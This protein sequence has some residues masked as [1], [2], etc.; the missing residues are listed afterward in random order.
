MGKCEIKHQERVL[1]C[2]SGGVSSTALLHLLEKAIPKERRR[3]VFFEWDILFI[4]MNETL[5][6]NSIDNEQITNISNEEKESYKNQLE[7]EL[8][9]KGYP[10]IN[11]YYQPFKLYE[12][13]TNLSQIKDPSALEDVVRLAVQNQ[14]ID[15]AIKNNY[16][17]VLLG[18]SANRLAIRVLGDISKGRGT[19]IPLMIAYNDD[20][21]KSVSICRPMKEFLLKEIG[22]YIYFHKLRIIHQNEPVT[23]KPVKTYSIDR[24]VETFIEGLQRE[25]PGTVHTILRTC[26]KLRVPKS[27]FDNESNPLVEELLSKNYILC[28]D[29]F[30]I[31]S[32]YDFDEFSKHNSQLV[33]HGCSRM[34]QSFKRE[35][36]INPDE[37]EN[38]SS[39]NRLEDDLFNNY[40]F[41]KEQKKLLSRKD[42]I[43]FLGDTLLNYSDNDENDNV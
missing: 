10:F 24:L 4:D 40:K 37:I 42:M 13:K 21:L 5:N 8:R 41:V 11:F 19:S 39:H 30:T 38:N 3:K 22:F 7:N 28:P 31:V 14:I 33:C 32:K 27:Y 17:K 9:E 18:T 36:Q 1:V 34:Y 2:W 12:N 26:D 29:C 15:F 20:R 6:L 16:R 43:S 35:K 23:M 25:F